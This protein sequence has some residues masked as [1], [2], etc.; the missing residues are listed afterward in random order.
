MFFYW[1]SQYFLRGR[2]VTN[3]FLLLFFTFSVS[4]SCLF[5][6]LCASHRINFSVGEKVTYQ[7][8]YNWHFIWV[9]AGEVTFS[10]DTGMLM[11]KKV[12]HFSGVGYTY[13]KWD[14]F[15]KVR[16]KY[17]SWADMQTLKPYRF[18]RIVNE[19]S[20]YL[21]EDCIFDYKRKKIYCVYAREPN[22]IR[23]DTLDMKDCVYDA[24]TL[25]YLTRTIDFYSFREG[26]V[27][28]LRVFVDRAIFDTYI[29]YLGYESRVIHKQKMMMHVLRAKLIMGTMFKEGEK[30]QI[31]VR[32]D[33]SQIPEYVEAE[34]L[35]GSIKAFR[36]K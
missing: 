31:W 14:W 36:I 18:R 32:D 35:V 11:G 6:Q 21:Y 16:D 13:K 3:F 29:K 19:G 28:D 1:L 20:Y 5:A 33:S 12:F 8:L 9:E 22:N 23:Y 10:V 34:I 24:L 30:M 17:E 26:D 4:Y 25:I 2:N 27:V 7:I 15:Y